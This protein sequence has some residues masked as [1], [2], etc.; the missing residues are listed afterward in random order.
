VSEVR[1]V[2]E[3]MVTRE[4]PDLLGWL[5]KRVSR[6]K[7]SHPVEMVALALL[8]AECC[9]LLVRKSWAYNEEPEAVFDGLR[10]WARYVA[11]ELGLEREGS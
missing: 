1:I 6:H 4:L 9:V 10:A 8:A 7:G 2:D 3:E 11:N 5:E